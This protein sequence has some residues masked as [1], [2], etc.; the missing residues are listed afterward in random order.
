MLCTFFKLLKCIR[1]IYDVYEMKMYHL[2]FCEWIYTCIFMFIRYIMNKE[3][4][5]YENIRIKDSHSKILIL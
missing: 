1:T 2:A 3:Y 5:Y 4:M